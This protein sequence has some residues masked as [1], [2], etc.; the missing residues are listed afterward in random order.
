MTYLNSLERRA[1]DL[2]RHGGASTC[3]YA[4]MGGRRSVCDVVIVPS[5]RMAV[6]VFSEREDNPGT[7]ITSW[8]ANLATEA[9]RLHLAHLAPDAIRWFERYP[10]A[11][12]IRGEE[13]VERVTLDW[14]GSVFLAPRWHAVA[15]AA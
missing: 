9:Y 10:A 13:L 6:A 11:P 2:I 3:V 12:G 14:D 7:A 4:G 5:A 8:F 15:I 1:M